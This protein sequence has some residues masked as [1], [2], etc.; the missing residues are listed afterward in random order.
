MLTSVSATQ[1]RRLRIILELSICCVVGCCVVVIVLVV[2]SCDSLVFY[3]E[4]VEVW[5]EAE[6]VSVIEKKVNWNSW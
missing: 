1:L 4:A 2:G 6:V 3:S 5:T